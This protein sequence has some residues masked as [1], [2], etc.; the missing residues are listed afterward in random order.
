MIKTLDEKELKQTY[1][2]M[3]VN[4]GLTTKA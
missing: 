3:P 1:F 4:C 2:E